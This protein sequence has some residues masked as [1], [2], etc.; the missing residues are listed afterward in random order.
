MIDQAS[1]R[2]AMQRL[3]APATAITTRDGDTPAGLMATAVCSLSADPPSLIVCINRS[4]TA[5]DAILRA[6][7]LAV[8]L[9]PDGAEDEA[10]HFAAAKGVA[11]F[12][13]GVWVTKVTGAPVLAT[14][15]VAFDCRIAS[16][17]AG[18]SH[19]VVVA[20]IVGLHFAEDSDPSCL[21]WHKRN[22]VRMERRAVA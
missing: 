9:F 19:T 4:A 13:R 22:F 5:H 20:E 2:E 8:S 11:R 6:G 18:Y 16:H 15:P 21:I 14:A 3:A 17:Q 7:I 12:D 10:T 1:F